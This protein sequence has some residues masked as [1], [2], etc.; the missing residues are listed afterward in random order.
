VEHNNRK[1]E[2]ADTMESILCTKQLLE[3]S[4]DVCDIAMSLDIML[5]TSVKPP[6]YLVESALAIILASAGDLQPARELSG[7]VSSKLFNKEVEN[8]LQR[9]SAVC[10][11]SS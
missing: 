3:G 2:I 11:I 1:K 7:T 9:L 6:D 5:E 10:E 8:L 4:D